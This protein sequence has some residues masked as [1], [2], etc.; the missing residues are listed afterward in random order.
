M[1][2]SIR[3]L[4]DPP[5]VWLGTSKTWIDQIGEPLQLGIKKNTFQNSDAEKVGV[6]VKCCKVLADNIGRLPINI[7]QSTETGNMIDREDYRQY[8]LHYSP[9]GIITSQAFFSS[10]EYNRNLRGNSFARIIRNPSNGRPIKFEL[11]PSA[12]VEGYKVVRG[13]LYYIYFKKLENGETKKTVVNAFDML[14]FKM[15]TKNG[16][17][18]MNP[19]EAQRMNMST[20]YKSKNVQDS[21]YE[22]NAFVP[23]FLKSTV[24]DANFIKP[25][26]EAMQQFKDKNVGPANA[27]TIATLPPFT[28]IQQLDMN[29][30]DAEFLA[31]SKFDAQQI[32][33]FY[34]VP[35]HFVGL[36]TGT[37]RNIEE[38]TRNFAT[39]GIGPIARMYRQELE[40]K[41]LTQKERE[42]GKSIEFVL[43]ALIETD[44]RTKTQYYKDMFGLGVMTGNQI[45][46][47]EGLPTY[48]GGETHFI[49]SNNLT[50]VNQ[51]EETP[52]IP[53]EEKDI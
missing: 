45:A 33:A 15:V 8:L 36:E 27:G 51:E 41:L 44:L 30:V 10:L 11:I 5:R 38:L 12:Q 18:G 4:F 32:A 19:I 35:P 39:F 26:N 49:P 34:D 6:A 2:N 50:P 53:K 17:W 28:E 21:Y 14:H 20:L 42:E 1:F 7:Y 52:E 22:N 25:F 47:L 3:E 40:F 13:Q 46:L 31:G 37:F 23:A 29:I 43:Q 9:D 48:A 24:P 16:I